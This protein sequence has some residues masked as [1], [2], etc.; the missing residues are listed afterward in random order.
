MS[1]LI[2][3]I[4]STYCL[5]AREMIYLKLKISSPEVF[6][7]SCGDKCITDFVFLQT[8]WHVFNGVL[9]FCFIF[10]VSHSLSCSSNEHASI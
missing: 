4:S 3:M 8:D 5:K 2:L 7:K 9:R 10:V 1:E 6:I